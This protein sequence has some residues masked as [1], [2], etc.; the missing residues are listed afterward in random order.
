MRETD[1]CVEMSLPSMGDSL[2]RGF[3]KLP[4]AHSLHAFG[5]SL[6]LS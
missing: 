6:I 2:A 1:A 5:L 4:A 3:W